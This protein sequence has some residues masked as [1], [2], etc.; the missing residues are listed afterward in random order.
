MRARQSKKK[1]QETN[2]K[3][4]WGDGGNGRDMV[5]WEKKRDTQAY[6]NV[7]K[8]GDISEENIGSERSI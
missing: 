5:I 2:T 7:Y 8:S 6:D 4:R 1:K 3:N